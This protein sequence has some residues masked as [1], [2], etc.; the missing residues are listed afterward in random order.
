LDEQP[1]AVRAQRR[2]KKRG[3]HPRIFKLGIAIL[4]A[5]ILLAPPRELI[6]I[7]QMRSALLAPA[8]ELS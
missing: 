5:A 6:S 4:S 3:N 2:S 7:R 1:N 8:P